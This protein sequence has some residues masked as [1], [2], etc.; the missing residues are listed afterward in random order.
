MR[1]IIQVTALPEGESNNPLLY[2]LCEDGTV[3]CR[4]VNPGEPRHIVPEIPQEPLPYNEP[5]K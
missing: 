1:K 5:K 4:R 2:A 3:W